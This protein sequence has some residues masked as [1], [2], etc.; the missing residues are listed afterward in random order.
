MTPSLLTLAVHTDAVALAWTDAADRDHV[1]LVRIVS[2]YPGTTH[3]MEGAYVVHLDGPETPH[4]WDGAVLDL[5]LEHGGEADGYSLDWPEAIGW[6]ER[7][8]VERSAA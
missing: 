6:C 1:T 7:G 3:R 8:R 5:W 2:L 4:G